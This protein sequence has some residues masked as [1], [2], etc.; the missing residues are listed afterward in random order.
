MKKKTVGIFIDSYF[1]LVDGVIMVVDNYAKELSKYMNVYVIIP[2]ID[3]NYNYN[4]LP[5]KVIKI[6]SINIPLI[7]YSLATPNKDKNI[8][9]L[10]K[11]NFDIIHIHS[12]F[13]IG[14]LGVKIAKLKNIPV[15]ATMHTQFKIEFKRYTK[16]NL[17]TN[18]MI[19]RIIKTYNACNQCWAVNENVK[20]VYI[21]YGYKGIPEVT[22]N[23]TDL[24]II[25][26]KIK[27]DNYINSLYHLNEDTQV[28]LFVGRINIVKNI[29]FITEVLNI[30]NK[31][32]FDFK[33]IFIGDGP[34]VDQLKG[35]IKDYHLKK[36]VILT[37][38]ITDRELL[39]KI[40]MRANIFIFPSLFDASSL[41]QVEAA[42]QKTPTIFIKGSVTSANIKDNYNGYLEENNPLK[43]AN[44]IIN[45]LENKAK[46]HKV[47]EKAYQE[48]YTPWNKIAKQVYKKYLEI[49][50]ENAK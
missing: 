7:N 40:Y 5:Y 3:K 34:D 49:I 21:E 26:N 44:R 46:Y 33:M 16:S 13:T 2:E 37:G 25:K 29:M 1:P 6:K 50:K 30:L 9:D 38:L 24:T 32:H 4:Q 43:F 18:L 28:L 27:N 31:K 42:S 22:K 12:P 47:C 36:K 39:K 14:N 19:K 10:K 17:L 48:V 15:I 20:K 41:V 8:E 35:R 11:I 45:I 23:G